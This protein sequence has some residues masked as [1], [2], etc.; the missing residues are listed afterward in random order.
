VPDLQI[1]R[2]TALQ[3]IAEELVG[4]GEDV[5]FFAGR[6]KTLD[7]DEHGSY[8]RPF[9][10]HKDYVRRLLG[11]AT[12]HQRFAVYK[13]R[14]MVV[15]WAM[16]LV[17]L[18]ELL[19]RP[20]SIISVVS[21]TEKD[22]GKLLDRIKIMHDSLPAHWKVGLPRIKTYN[23]K[24]GIIV[25]MVAVFPGDLPAAT[26]EACATNGNPGRGQTVSLCYWDEIG[27]QKD[28][29]CRHMY[30]ALR[31]TLEGGGRLIMSSTPP[32]STEHFWNVFCEGRYFGDAEA[33]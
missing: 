28:D 12:Q 17:C 23:G 7:R 1:D 24:G 30:S 22:A 21:M 26:I 5:E 29:E 16:L 13:S 25:R 3:L 15:T 9:P 10:I 18:H 32:R 4:A 8:L 6:V 14:Q 19:F 2:A 33:A 31:P 11:L 27:E 20:G